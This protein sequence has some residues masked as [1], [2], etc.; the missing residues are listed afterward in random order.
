MT[1]T[2]TACKRNQWACGAIVWASAFEFN[3]D[4]TT[5]A[6]HQQPIKGMLAY[7]RYPDM[8]KPPNNVGSPR[9]FIPFKKNS[10]TELTWSKSVSINSRDIADTENEAKDLYNQRVRENIQWFENALDDLKRCLL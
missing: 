10:T 1:A 5:M 2:T 8:I 3:R 6:C 7:G 9:Y 4:K